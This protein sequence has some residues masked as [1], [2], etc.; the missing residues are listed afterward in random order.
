LQ[1]THALA[2]KVLTPGGGFGPVDDNGYGVSYII[3]AKE[4]ITFHIS[5]RYSSES[6]SSKRFAE[7]IK[8]AMNDIATIFE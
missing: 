8:Q 7:N 6:T 1:E 2:D 3:M 4:L 5:S